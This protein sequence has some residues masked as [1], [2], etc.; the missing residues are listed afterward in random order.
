MAWKVRTGLYVEPN[1]QR[2]KW[3]LLRFELLRPDFKRS[4][5]VLDYSTMDVK[6]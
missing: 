1:Y 3:S 2:P 5:I 6:V 4:I